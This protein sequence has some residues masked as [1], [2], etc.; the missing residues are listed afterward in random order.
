MQAPL[1]DTMDSHRLVLWAQSV[2]VGKGGKK[3][4]APGSEHAGAWGE[5]SYSC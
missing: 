5:G 2:E 4:V 1:S 3:R